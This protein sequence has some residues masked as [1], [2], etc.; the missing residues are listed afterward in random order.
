MR[1]RT[2]TCIP[3]DNGEIRA[4]WEPDIGNFACEGEISVFNVMSIAVLDCIDV[5]DIS[6]QSD[7]LL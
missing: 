2:T 6:L 3:V 4:Q 1:S 5:S 7:K